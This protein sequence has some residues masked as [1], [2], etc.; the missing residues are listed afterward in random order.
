M[1]S[2]ADPAVGFCFDPSVDFLQGALVKGSLVEICAVVVGVGLQKVLLDG[3]AG[4][5]FEP[6]RIGQFQA[7]VPGKGIQIAANKAIEPIFVH[8]QRLLHLGERLPLGSVGRHSQSS[9]YRQRGNQ[10]V[11]VAFISG[12]EQPQGKV[13]GRCRVRL[14]H[15]SGSAPVRSNVFHQICRLHAGGKG[16]AACQLQ[17][18]K[19]RQQQG[20]R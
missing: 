8:A 2:P 6:N 16:R 3:E 15:R 19:D 1:K 20:D 5:V 14:L 9:K 17:A 10:A 12:P 11:F 13:C 7:V 4:I 18:Q